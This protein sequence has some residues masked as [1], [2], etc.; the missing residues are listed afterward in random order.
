MKNINIKKTTQDI[1]KWTT[2]GGSAVISVGAIMA[3]TKVKDVKS[4]I[5]PLVTLLVG[6]SAFSYAMT[7]KVGF[8]PK[9]DSGA[10]ETK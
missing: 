1:L 2:I 3:L 5:M 4:A 9:T 7:E 6:V 10:T 8:I